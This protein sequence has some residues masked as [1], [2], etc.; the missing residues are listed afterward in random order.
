VHNGKKIILL[1]LTL[2]EIVQC[3]RAIAETARR[4]S[5]IQHASPVKLEQTAPSSSSNAIKLKSYAMLATK[6]DLSVST[7]VDVSFYALMCRQVL[8]SL[9]DITT[10]LPRAITNLLQEFKDV[11]PLRYPR[12][13]HL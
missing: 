9:E 10:T 11:F 5:E 13:C 2:N 7:N 3:D 4:E 6:S 8:F 12:G 1:S